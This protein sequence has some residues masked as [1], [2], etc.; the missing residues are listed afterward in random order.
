MAGFDFIKDRVITI[1]GFS[2]GYAMTGWRV[3]YLAATK[4]IADA[5]DKMQSQITSGT[6][7]IAQKA[8][9]GALKG[10]RASAEEMT[11]A[12]KRRRDLVLG[13]DERN[14]GH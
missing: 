9:V 6:C 7:S 5:C 1:N 3:G 8:A 12:Y 2:K 4:E 10:G 14:S 11:E 13:F